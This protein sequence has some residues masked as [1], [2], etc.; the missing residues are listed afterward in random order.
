M[1]RTW[2]THGS[3]FLSSRLTPPRN[4]CDKEKMV[5]ITGS[6]SFLRTRL[7][8][9]LSLYRIKSDDHYIRPLKASVST[10]ESFTSDAS[11]TDNQS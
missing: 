6:C 3:V 9:S 7:L 8:I 11:I 5:I 4:T 2:Q 1:Q 10:I